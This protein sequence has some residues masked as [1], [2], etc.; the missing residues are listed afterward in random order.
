MAL[1]LH[2]VL[3]GALFKSAFIFAGFCKKGAMRYRKVS[4]IK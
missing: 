2:I 1:A 3:G 4:G